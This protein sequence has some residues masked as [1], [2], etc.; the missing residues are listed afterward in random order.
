MNTYD[1]IIKKYNLSPVREHYLP[2]RNMNRNN[3]A[4]L[5]HELGFTKGAEVGVETGAYSQVLCEANPDLELFC[6]D[7]YSPGAYEPD[8]N[9]I[10]YRMDHFEKM[11]T[12]AK[13]TLADYNANVIRKTSLDASR[14]FEDNSL[15]FVYIDGNHSFVNVAIDI[16]EWS[17]KVRPGGIVSGHDFAFFS[18]K[19]Q[20][21]VKY[22][23]LTYTK[24]YG[25]KPFFVAGAEEMDE[26]GIV[27][28]KFR[29]WFWVKR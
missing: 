15:D 26:P 7:P 22:V 9:G 10:D 1:Y 2:I 28:D 11:Y 8:I 19:K 6:V 27:R 23:V 24:A 14:N 16:H 4:E 25:I 20:N 5:F 13:E 29:S 12:R 3:L 21:H 18:S 17:K